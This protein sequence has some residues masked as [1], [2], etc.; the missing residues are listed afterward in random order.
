MLESVLEN[1][2][3]I[4]LVLLAVFVLI[5]PAICNGE[6][7]GARDILLATIFYP[8]WFLPLVLFLIVTAIHAIWTNNTFDKSWDTIM[9]KKIFIEL[10]G[11]KEK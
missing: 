7:M 8:L 1:L 10:L 2:F 3:I 5:V 11:E 6:G 4:Y 9:S